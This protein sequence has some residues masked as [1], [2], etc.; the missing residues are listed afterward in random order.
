VLNHIPGETAAVRHLGELE[1][2]HPGVTVLVPASSDTRWRAVIV[3]G[4]IPGDGRAAILTSRLPSELLDK[5]AALFG[6]P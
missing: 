2:A 4:A 6:G 1:Q 3:A 5:L